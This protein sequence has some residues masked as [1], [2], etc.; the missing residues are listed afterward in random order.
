M[1]D[2]I[3][4]RSVL[5]TGGTKG[6]GKGIAAGFANAG[7]NVVIT[8]RDAAAG[9]RTAA[10]LTATAAAAS[11][12]GGTVTYVSGDVGDQASCAE[13]VAATIAAHG[14]LDV[15]CCNAGIFPA[16]PLAEMTSAELDE[17]LGTNLKGTFFTVQAALSALRDSGHGRVI[18]TSSITGPITGFAG[19]SH[20]GAS[21]AG[22]LGF[23]RSAALEF[24]RSGITVNAVMPGNIITEGLD[25]LGAD[26]LA[27]MEASIPLGRL[28][29]VADI[30]NAAL[31]LASDEAGYITAQTIVVDGG[32]TV[33]ES[34]EAMV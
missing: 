21:K 5:V 16:S 17:V 34:L 31:F 9:E 3:R 10:E 15:V 1:F 4:G 28:G 8:G 23:M 27:S 26:Y 20:Y 29:S 18:L 11:P 30:A 13:V 2:S 6:I 24:A 25:D 19:W 7:A 14:G 32:Q 22:Q 33:P 12:G